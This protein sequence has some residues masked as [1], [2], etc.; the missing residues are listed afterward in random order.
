MKIIVFSDS[1]GRTS[2]MRDVMIAHPDA[3]LFVHLGDGNAE[4]VRLADELSRPAFSVRG[5]CD[6]F[7]SGVPDTATLEL[8]G[9]RI[10]L[11]HGHLFSAKSGTYALIREGMAR[12]A[13]LVLF[14]HTHRPLERTVD[15]GERYMT[16]FNPG[17]V[18]IGESYGVV[19][20]LPAGILCSVVE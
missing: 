5:N 19:E 2:L 18:G 9:Y 12:N 15:L 10:M 16:L 6:M 11:T 17:S 4:F 1:H 14:G 8:G 13:D 7:T 3:E 20:L